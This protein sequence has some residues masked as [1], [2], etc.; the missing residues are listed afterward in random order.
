MKKI[1]YILGFSLLLGGCA[2]LTKTQINCINQY[3]ETTENF[4]SFP[5]KIMTELSEIRVKRG[6]YF[7]NSLTDPKLHIKEIDEIFNQKKFDNEVSK[8]VD[9]TFKIIDKYAQSLVLLSSDRY[10]KKIEKNLTD[11]G[12]GIDSLITLNNSI[13]GTTKIPTGIGSAV[14]KLIVLGGKQY[15]RAKQAKEIKKFVNLADTLVS[16][17]TTNLLEYLQS[18]TINEL[19]ENEE[20]GISESYL[21]YLQQ[22]NKE[23]RTMSISSDSKDTINSISVSISKPSIENEMDYLDLKSKIDGVKTLQQQTI[24][25]TK[26]LRKTHKKLLLEIEGKKSLKQTI[27]ELQGLFEDINDLKKTVQKIDTK[28]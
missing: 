25:A 21:S 16:A 26:N 10:I 11:F 9:V 20:R 24:R 28:N 23:T 2:T 3:A 1:I 27:K 19:I 13:D 4:S 14:G 18:E 15:Y 7:A 22:I 8:K 17:M 6:V 12:I 5:S